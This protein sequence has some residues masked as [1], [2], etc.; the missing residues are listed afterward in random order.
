MAASVLEDALAV[1]A[2]GSTEGDRA[3]T[4]A[5]EALAVAGGALAAEASTVAE[6]LAVAGGA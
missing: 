4:V 3:L 6:V 5:A 1:A 2:E